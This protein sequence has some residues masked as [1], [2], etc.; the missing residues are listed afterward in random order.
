MNRSGWERPGI[1]QLKIDNP[2]TEQG[3]FTLYW[4]KVARAT[5]VK[6]EM[7]D[8]PGFGTP[9]L[10]F[11]ESAYQL[12]LWNLTDG[13]YYFRARAYK[14]VTPGAWSKVINV[15]VDAG[16]MFKRMRPK[17]RGMSSIIKKRMAH[18]YTC[19]ALLQD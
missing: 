1:P 6:V 8:S 12:D 17:A 2:V 5:H 19:H 15:T 10:Y 16:P 9:D 18:I 13:T 4:G 7:D 14:D 3:N 11:M